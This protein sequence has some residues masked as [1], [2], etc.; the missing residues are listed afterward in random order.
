MKLTI[1][2]SGTC[3]PS[4]ERSSPANFLKILNTEIIIDFGPG[5]MHQLLKAKIDYKTIDVV[6]LT[7]FH[8]DHASELHSFIQALNWTP[9]F[10]RKKDLILIG[11][12][13]FKN[14]FKNTINSNPL[15]DSYKIKIKEIRNYLAFNGFKVKCVKTIHN[16]ESIGYKFIEK[17]KSIVITG[18]CDYDLNLIKF[19]K[20]SNLLLTECSFPNDL[21]MKGHLVPKECGEIAKQAN[22]GKLV[23]THLYPTSPEAVR[24][25]ETKKV[26]K[27]TVLAN[28]LLTINI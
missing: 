19:S 17:T 12:V 27:N 21:K 4:L 13:G 14:F 28:D 7:H 25:K 11:P 2:G 5:T 6:C 20:N 22:V 15:S 1:L 26:F 23:L 8:P 10:K 3:V 16:Q 18:D 24:L 9:N